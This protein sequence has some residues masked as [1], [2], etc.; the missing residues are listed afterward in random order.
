MSHRVV[1]ELPDADAPTPPATMEGLNRYGSARTMQSAPAASSSASDFGCINKASSWR[2]IRRGRK[3]SILTR[4][5]WSNYNPNSDRQMRE[6]SNFTT[7]SSATEE[8]GLLLNK[9]SMESG[10]ESIKESTSEEEVATPWEGLVEM[11]TENKINYL[12]V[13]IPFAV[14]SHKAGWSDGSIFIL[15]FLAMVPLASMLGV[16]TEEL[17][18]HTNDVIG[19][20]INATFG[21]AVELVVAIQ[22][23]LAGDFRVVQASLIGSVFSNLLL[24][25]GMCFLFGGMKFKE[26]EF[27]AQGVVASISLLGFS[28]VA[29]LLPEFFG[30]VGEDSEDT[31]TISRLAA[32]LLI[33]MYGL[34]LWFQL[35]THVHLFQGDDEELALIPFSWALT[36][37]VVIT[38]IVTILSEFLVASIDGFCEEFNLGRSFVGLIILPVVGN[39]VEHISAVSVAMK[40]KMDLALGVALGSSVQIALF[41]LPVTVVVGWVTG[42]E[43]T[44]KFPQFEVALYLMSVIIVSMCLSNARSNWL[45]GSLLISLYA[46][47][48]VGIYFEKDLE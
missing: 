22:A 17:A 24:V 43:M 12:F 5:R 45:E 39:A 36:G 3:L 19:G 33:I 13:F 4:R 18:A 48:A 25:L 26:Q 1:F 20:L 21:N 40:N 47:I 10:G 42:R 8:T 9:G 30:G 6:G 46:L 31:A 2:K 11:F 44:M 16:F 41:V 35:K 7:D 28:G 14:W 27:I 32:L 23:L 29:L 34:L 37:L 38:A 15:N